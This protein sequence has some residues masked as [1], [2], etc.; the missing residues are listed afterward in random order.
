MRLAAYSTARDIEQKVFL[1][2]APPL[3]QF[4]DGHLV[5]GGVQTRRTPPIRESSGV[6]AHRARRDRAGSTICRNRMRSASYS[7]QF[8]GKRFAD[9]RSA[10]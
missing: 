2:L 9:A 4:F 1:L 10:A 7:K 6:A 5:L 8:A 3:I